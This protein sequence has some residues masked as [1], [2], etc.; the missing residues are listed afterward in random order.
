MYLDYQDT[1]KMKA[2]VTK[3]QIKIIHKK[4]ISRTPDEGSS[5]NSS[6]CRNRRSL[7]MIERECEKVE[8]TIKDHQ[9]KLVIKQEYDIK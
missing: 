6:L 9:P 2:K 4:Q 7:L 5:N 8:K 1:D 3:D